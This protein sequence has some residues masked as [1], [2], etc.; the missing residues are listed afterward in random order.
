[1]VLS[2]DLAACLSRGRAALGLDYKPLPP[3]EVLLISCEDDFSDTIA[4]R[5]L[6]AEADLSRIFKV[7]GI[8][9]EGGKITPFGMWHYQEMEATLRARP[10]IRLVVIDPAGAY[11]GNS[12]VDDYKDSELRTLLGPMADVAARLEVIILLI[13]HLIKGATTRA[14]HKV[15]G[16]A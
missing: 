1:S 5:L 7:D 12:G 11:I 3:S 14:V 16:S 9:D 10:N 6:A 4:P 15:S 13:K 8:K 2:L